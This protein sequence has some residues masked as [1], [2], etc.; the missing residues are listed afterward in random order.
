MFYTNRE[1]TKVEMKEIALKAKSEILITLPSNKNS[2]IYRVLN[3]EEGVLVVQNVDCAYNVYVLD[4]NVEVLY[5]GDKAIKCGINSITTSSGAPITIDVNCDKFVYQKEVTSTL[6]Q[7]APIEVGDE[8]AGYTDEDIYVH[9]TV[10]AASD[11]QLVLNCF[12]TKTENAFFAILDKNTLNSDGDWKIYVENTGKRLLI[13]KNTGKRSLIDK[14]TGKRL[15]IDSSIV[16][17]NK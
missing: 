6:K 17:W 3:N 5:Q 14:N 7:E 11:T 12:D 9:I 2:D 13:D 10:A 1:V 4:N 8:F 15:L 16:R